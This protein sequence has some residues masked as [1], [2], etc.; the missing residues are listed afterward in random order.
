MSEIIRNDCHIR[1]DGTELEK[2]G[3]PRRCDPFW[4]LSLKEA[5]EHTLEA[6]EM[7]KKMLPEDKI[8]ALIPLRDPLA[9]NR[10]WWIGL[11]FLPFLSPKTHSSSYLAKRLGALSCNCGR[12]RRLLPST[13]EI[14]LHIS[15]KERKDQIG[16]QSQESHQ[17]CLL[18]TGKPF[19]PSPPQRYRAPREQGGARCYPCY[20]KA[21]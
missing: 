14:V 20:L 21:R 7:S 6:E 16:A 3:I 9:S 18:P 2:I 13:G 12:G 15:V 1:F 8:N 17:E 10:A 19:P 4:K 11:E 5:L